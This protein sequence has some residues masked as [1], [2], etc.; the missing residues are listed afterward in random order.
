MKL[1]IFSII[2][3]WFL[4]SFTALA[5]PL[6]GEWESVGWICQDE[7]HIFT[8]CSI[9]NNL[10]NCEDKT[11]GFKANS[12]IF[13]LKMNLRSPSE[14]PQLL[15]EFQIILEFHP[16]D[17]MCDMNS[18]LSATSPAVPDWLQKFLGI[19]I[20]CLYSFTQEDTLLFT[21]SHSSLGEITRFQNSFSIIG[22]EIDR[23][24]IIKHGLNGLAKGYLKAEN[25]TKE[26]YC[27]ENYFLNQLL[28]EEK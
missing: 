17:N 1:C 18:K 4:F 2:L 26:D 10:L 8:T 24:L 25:K 19:Y 23:F 13:S 15:K 6:I 16:N 21:T 22:N 20:E 7:T 27:G 9:E 5:N 12:P 28:R 3:C 11:S 14:K